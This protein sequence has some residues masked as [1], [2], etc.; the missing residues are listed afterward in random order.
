MGLEAKAAEWLNNPLDPQKLQMLCT[1][2][3]PL[4]PV[5]RI[6]ILYSLAIR[7]G[8][9]QQEALDA[10][11]KSDPR[12]AEFVLKDPSIPAGLVD[13]FAQ[14]FPTETNVA[15]QCLSHPQIHQNTLRLIYS[16]NMDQENVL[17]VLAEKHSFLENDLEL[18]K[19]LIESNFVPALQKDKL[20]SLFPDLAPEPTPVVDDSK[21]PETLEEVDVDKEM[22]PEEV[23]RFDRRVRNLRKELSGLTMGKK[24]A[25]AMKGNKETRDIMIKQPELIIKKAVL[26]NPK[27]TEEEVISLTLERTVDSDILR[28]IS[29]NREWVKNYRVKVNMVNNPKTP[30]G[31]AMGYLTSLLIGDLERLSKSKNVAAAIRT[32]ADKLYKLKKRQ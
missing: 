24:I 30:L 16:N 9:G 27:I 2:L 4:P 17:E 13:Y 15:I 28:E 21:E 31:I 25:L 32:A 22:P 5:E 1:G 8:E 7:Q 23:E 12:D 20:R 19:V 18:V 6:F 14:L 10:L 11:Q 26:A 29:L 3:L